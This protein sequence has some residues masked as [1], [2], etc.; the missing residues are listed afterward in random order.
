[1]RTLFGIELNTINTVEEPMVEKWL[2]TPCVLEWKHKTHCLVPRAEG[3]QT[4][5]DLKAMLLDS[6]AD[7]PETRELYEEWVAEQE[8]R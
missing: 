8:E 4:P 2:C 3:E 7:D 6:L 1:M 5:V